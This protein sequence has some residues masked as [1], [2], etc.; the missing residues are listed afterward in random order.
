MISE[1]A[2][3]CLAV[4]SPAVAV[5]GSP[6]S[7]RSPRPGSGWE[8]AF[9]ISERAVAGLA[10]AGPAVA[11]PAELAWLWLARQQGGLVAGLERKSVTSSANKGGRAGGGVGVSAGGGVGRRRGSAEAGAA[12]P[13]WRSGGNKPS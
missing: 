6:S 10:V 11:G 7:L 9:M 5:A 4:A 12:E 1:R 13:S 2:I 3:A 8:P